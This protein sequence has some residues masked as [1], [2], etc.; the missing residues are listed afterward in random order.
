MKTEEH[1]LIC[2][3]RYALSKQSYIVT[4]TCDFITQH[5]EKLSNECKRILIIDISRELEWC[6]KQGIPCG[7][8]NDELDWQKLLN[9]LKGE[10]QKKPEDYKVNRKQENIQSNS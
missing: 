3:V 10:S 1:L 8:A 4:T 2:A 7:Y 5:C 6:R 9:V